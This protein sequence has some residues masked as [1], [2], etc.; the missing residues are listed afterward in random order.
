MKKIYYFLIIII[1]LLNIILFARILELIYLPGELTPLEKARQGA[2]AAIQYSEELAAS[3]GIEEQRSVVDILARF[4]Y[5]IER[6][7][8]AEE[9]ASL[10][11]DFGRQTQDIIFQEAQNNQLN[12]ILNLV[13]SQQL[14]EEGSITISR[15]GDRT[16]FLDP[17]QILKKEIREGIE[18]IAT[19]QTI[20]IKIKERKA[21]IITAGD[22]FN[23][24]DFLQTRV[25]S[26]E[27]Q[28]KLLGQ[29]AGYEPMTGPGIIVNIYDDSKKMHDSGV[30]H[31]SDI[32]N[33]INELMTA[34]ARGVEVGGQRLTVNSAIRC[35]GPT[36]LVN[37]KPVAVNPVIVRA[38]GIP[39]VLTSSLD[40][41]KKQ[42]QAFNIRVE[43]IEKEEIT[44]D[45]QRG[46]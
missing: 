41:I 40:I 42:L 20:E 32:R 30:V 7:D 4:R 26:L 3:Y 38:I 2:E 24:V 37:N 11:L 45:G 35:V 43:V 39:R 31:D 14:P 36:I 29:K 46:E 17:D 13:N 10:L 5:E 1:L 25:A 27:R 16:I 22:I 21:V 28:L 44:L 9:V 33:L 12:W 18:G 6:A 19:N 34:G 23:Q 15:K 8:N